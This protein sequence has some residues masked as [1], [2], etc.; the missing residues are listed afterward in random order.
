MHANDSLISPRL[1]GDAG[2]RGG[3]RGLAVGLDGRIGVA[4]SNRP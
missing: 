2:E 1:D 4:I 3:G